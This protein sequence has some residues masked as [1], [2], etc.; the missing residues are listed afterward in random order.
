MIYIV[1]HGQTNW[2]LENRFQGQAN[3]DINEKGIK[4]ANET[5]EKLSKIKFHKIYS[6]PLKRALTTA[7]II[8]ENDIIIDDRLAER[9]NG[10][11]EGKDKKIY[12]DK[13]NFYL[14]EEN[15]YGIEP[16]S[17]YKKRIYEFLDEITKKYNGEDIL[18]VTHSVVS[19]IIRCY[20]EGEP[21]NND[22]DSYK[23]GN[24]EIMK[25]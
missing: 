14:L 7:K 19:V 8:T 6:S 4:Q 22:Y 1:R 12:K 13:I 24:A 17:K 25:Y 18:I 3:I 23:L 15:S 2:N 5:K 10:E 9:Y 21:Q 16:F 11:L 20:F